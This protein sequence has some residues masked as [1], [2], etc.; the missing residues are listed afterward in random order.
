[1]KTE[2]IDDLTKDR[3]KLKY[4]V[5]QLNL[6]HNNEDKE[7]SVKY[8]KLADNLGRI[9]D[10]AAK[11]QEAVEA[12]PEPANRNVKA[13]VGSNMD[14]I[15]N[16]V[17]T[18]NDFI[19]HGKSD[20]M[21]VTGKTRALSPS[22]KHKLLLACDEDCRKE[23]TASSSTAAPAQA[24]VVNP[25]AARD[26]RKRSTSR[27][28]KMPKAVAEGKESYRGVQLNPLGRT[29][30]RSEATRGHSLCPREAA[31]H[32]LPQEAKLR[33]EQST[34]RMRSSTGRGSSLTRRKWRCSLPHLAT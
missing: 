25:P 26:A 21:E 4:E 11:V 1:M 18:V 31:L 32:H 20:I 34:C 27:N 2:E 14:E 22:V 5:E 28:N 3:D 10:L 12:L 8:R 30:P 29:P 6:T 7:K 24:A 33:P 13:E 19:S 9:A 17:Y 16:R 23:S 15:T